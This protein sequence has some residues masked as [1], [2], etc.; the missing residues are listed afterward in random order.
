MGGG[1]LT[2]Q[3]LRFTVSP[4]D[5][6]TDSLSSAKHYVTDEMV[7]CNPGMLIRCQAIFSVCLHGY[8]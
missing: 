3:A 7:I 1:D 2:I 6:L 4:D 5:V 8:N